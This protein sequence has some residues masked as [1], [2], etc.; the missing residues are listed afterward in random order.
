MTAQLAWGIGLRTG[1][2]PQPV[3]AKDVALVVSQLGQ[4]QGSGRS[5]GGVTLLTQLPQQSGLGCG[6]VQ[7]VTTGT[8][9]ACL[10]PQ[11]CIHQGSGSRGTMPGL[12]VPDVKALDRRRLAGDESSHAPTLGHAVPARHCCLPSPLPAGRAACLPRSVVAHPGEGHHCPT[13]QRQAITQGQE[14]AAVTGCLGTDLAVGTGLCSEGT[15]R[16]PISG[17]WHKHGIP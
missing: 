8:T 10:L 3:R 2:S 1:E 14:C 11:A 6:R 16:C 4:C 7:E 17:H 13:K 5:L 15:A 12:P 9:S